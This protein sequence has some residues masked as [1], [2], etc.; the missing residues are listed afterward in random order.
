VPT[1][2]LDTTSTRWLKPCPRRPQSASLSKS[3]ASPPSTGNAFCGVLLATVVTR[4]FSYRTHA[5][6]DHAAGA[7]DTQW[8]RDRRSLEQLQGDANEVV[9]ASA[10]GTLL[11][12]LQSNFYAVVAGRPGLCTALRPEVLP[13]TVRRL[14]QRL[15]AR[16]GILVDGAGASVADLAYGGSG[17]F[18]VCVSVILVVGNPR[19][20]SRTAGA[21]LTSTSRLVLPIDEL[22]VYPDAQEAGAP[23]LPYLKIALDAAPPEAE[24]RQ[25]V[26]RLVAAVAAECR[27][28]ATP[29]LPPA[30]A[31]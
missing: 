8:L 6:R 28:A 5:R 30:T 4:I 19:M 16:D 7:K 1:T 23:V 3:A 31:E 27:A 15:C 17:V 14:V 9:L 26:A 10:D 2:W 21:F 24:S 11:E 22:H 29:I 20:H 12:G 13:G 18:F 25:V